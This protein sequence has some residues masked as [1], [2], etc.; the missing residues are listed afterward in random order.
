MNYRKN[1]SSTLSLD[2]NIF[3]LLTTQQD[4]LLFLNPIYWKF[5]LLYQN[6]QSPAVEEWMIFWV[7]GLPGPGIYFVYH[8]NLGEGRWEPEFP[9]DQN[10]NLWS[11]NKVWMTKLQLYYSIP[12]NSIQFRS[13]QFYSILFCSILFYSVL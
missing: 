3:H 4:L 6:L 8:C 9:Q 7:I 13:A 10:G 11:R 5:L 1:T 2:S 12:F